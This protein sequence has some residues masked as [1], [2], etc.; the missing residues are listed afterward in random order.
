MGEL[1]SFL[2]AVG[3]AGDPL[4]LDHGRPLVHHPME[5]G[6]RM[7]DRRNPKPSLELV[8]KA[9]LSALF[10]PR[11]PKKL[12]NTLCIL[13]FSGAGVVTIVPIAILDRFQDQPIWEISGFLFSA[14]P[15]MKTILVFAISVIFLL[16]AICHA[17]SADISNSNFFAKSSDTGSGGNWFATATSA[18]AATITF[19]GGPDAI[20]ASAFPA[21]QA[22]ERKF[23]GV[24][25]PVPKP[26]FTGFSK[27]DFLLPGGQQISSLGSGSSFGPNF[28]G[29]YT[30]DW[31][32]RI[33]S[34]GLV[35]GTDTW[36]AKVTAGD[37]WNIYPTDLA[38]LGSTY[39]L[40]IPFAINSAS[41][42]LGGSGVTSGYELDV[43]YSTTTSTDNLLDISV[44]GNH[45]IVTPSANYSMSQLQLFQESSPETAPTGSSPPPGTPISFSGLESYLNTDI[46][47][48]GNLIAPVYLGVVL[49]GIPMPTALFPDGS[50][51]STGASSMVFET[52]VPEPSSIVLAAFGFVGMAA[53]GW[54]RRNRPA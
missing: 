47:G 37:P 50:V 20:N 16:P 32:L 21:T 1:N 44:I 23:N 9:T 31:N 29:L 4:T 10:G 14:D 6:R 54:R 43:T 28:F 45:A 18:L 12:R 8:H 25:A 2:F 15:L 26:V 42:A 22:I 30:A 48:S 5:H 38:G 49:N 52:S 36:S 34:S 11:E 39:S 3:K 40:Y 17:A 33:N 51:A 35:P 7:A 46:D 13:A 19:R 41:A 27:V 24:L 53:R